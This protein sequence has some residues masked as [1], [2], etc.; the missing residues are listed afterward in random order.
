MNPDLPRRSGA[1]ALRAAVFAGILALLALLS[2]A[3][4]PAAATKKTLARDMAYYYK[5][6]KDKGLGP[7][8]RLYILD[9]L[10]KKYRD[11]DFD[12]TD[13]YREIDR[14]S[15]AKAKLKK[16][17]PAAET[18]PPAQAPEKTR[19]ARRLAVLSD[20]LATES[21]GYS[22]LT[23][24]AAPGPVEFDEDS[25]RDPAGAQPPVVLLY[26]RG[27][28]EDLEP[29][30]KNFRVKEGLIR[31]V[32]TR[33]VSADPPVI[34][35]S[36][37]LREDRPFRTEQSDGRII[38]TVLKAGPTVQAAVPEPVPPEPAPPPAE[39]PKS[40]GSVYVLGAVKSPGPYE[41]S[42]DLTLMQSIY[43]AGGFDKDAKVD[44]IRLIRSDQG[45][46]VSW[47][48]DLNDILKR[49]PE[50][51]VQLKPGDQVLVPEKGSITKRMGGRERVLPWV[52][53]LISL[54]LVLG[55]LI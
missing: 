34:K 24:T 16:T 14:W 41:L 5:V 44:R 29:L 51:D 1:A 52:G 42:G 2:A 9:R 27:A 45:T 40:K 13:L 7:N 37:S 18:E 55:F 31:Q 38:L 54:G 47:E 3:P 48:Y 11:A 53:F 6:S 46:K 28:R 50:E 19:P 12:L 23:L 25:A 4:A 20:I 21:T 17:A 10:R 32:Q 36:V 30:L 22:R 33:T 43:L 15:A 26:I 35:V 39:A 8:D 49:R